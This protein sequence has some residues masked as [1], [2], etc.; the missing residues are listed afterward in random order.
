MKPNNVEIKCNGETTEVFINGE[1][2]ENVKS[3]IFRHYEDDKPELEIT[4][5]IEPS[6]GWI[7]GV[8]MTTLVDCR[9]KSD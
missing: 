4:Y 5:D 8:T 3:C 2:Q 9:N 6:I 7:G 1:K